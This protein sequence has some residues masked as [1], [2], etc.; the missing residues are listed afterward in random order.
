VTAA[1]A[2]TELAVTW[3]NLWKG[4]RGFMAFRRVRHAWIV[5][6]MVPVGPESGFSNVPPAALA[7]TLRR[8]GRPR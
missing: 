8:T 3:Q 5:L 4:I 1:T 6:L 2:L 7:V